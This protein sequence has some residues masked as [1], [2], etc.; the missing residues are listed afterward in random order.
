MQPGSKQISSATY[1]S[2]FSSKKEVVCFLQ[3]SVNSYIAPSN[4]LSIYFLKQLVSGQKK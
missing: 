2:K 4:T 1:G 3:V